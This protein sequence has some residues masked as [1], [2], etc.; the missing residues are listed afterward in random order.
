LGRILG[1]PLL[2]YGF[3]GSCL[4]QPEVAEL[5]GE[6]TFEGATPSAVVM[7]CLPNMQGDD[8][9]QITNATLAVLKILTAKFA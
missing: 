5:L 3:S 4:M 2:N 9:A 7:D 6:A 8:P 1:V